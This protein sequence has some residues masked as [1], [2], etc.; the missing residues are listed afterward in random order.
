MKIKKID[1]A[2]NP[3][4]KK[5]LSL[6]KSKGILEHNECLIGGEKII[7]ELL[8]NQRVPTTAYF[9]YT[10]ADHPLLQ[11]FPRHALIELPKKLFQDLDVIGTPGPLLVAPVPEFKPADLTSPANVTEVLC[12]LGDPN[13]LGALLRSA[14]AFGVTRAVLLRECCH[15]FHPK[16]IKSSAGTVFSFVFS[17]GPSI[18]NLQSVS[19]LVAL[20]MAG[21]TPESLDSSK[22]YRLLLGE[23]GQ[24]LPQLPS[25]VRR[26]AIP[27]AAGVESLNATVAASL[28]LYSLRPR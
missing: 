19:D 21:E 3:I 15:P 5:L 10:D 25:T 9:V 27:M 28:V 24:G 1:S 13:N 22:A 7:R 17:A 4:Y 8:Q 2:A 20:D 16:V 11:D 6:T 14:R 18:Q 23:E 12:G 26:I